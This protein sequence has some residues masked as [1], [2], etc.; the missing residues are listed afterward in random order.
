MPQQT[1]PKQETLTIQT[2][3]GEINY[4]QEGIIAFPQGLFGFSQLREFVLAPLPGV[5]ETTFQLLQSIED[6]NL[7]FLMHPMVNGPW[8]DTEV[9]DACKDLNLVRKNVQVFTI[10][11]MDKTDESIMWTCNQRAPILLDMVNRVS[12]QWIFMNQAYELRAPLEL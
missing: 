2:R 3:F 7:A 1:C 12:Y 8:S 6:T 9:Q 5:P 11:T 10:V 4:G